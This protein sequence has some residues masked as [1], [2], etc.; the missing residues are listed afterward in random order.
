MFTRLPDPALRPE[1]LSI[2]FEFEGR[3]LKGLDGDSVA[4]ALAANGI[5]RLGAIPGREA[6]RGPYCLMG[7]CFECLVVIND[8]ASQQACRIPLAPGMR[9]RAQVGWREPSA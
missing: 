1:R 2:P 5:L 8:E 4:A 3:P 7:V 6:G 9:I